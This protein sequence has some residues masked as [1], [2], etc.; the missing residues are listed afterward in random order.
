MSTQNL[1]PVLVAF[2]IS[3]NT[4][5]TRSYKEAASQTFKKGEAVYI[6]GS[7]YV[8]EYTASIDDGT[9]RMIGFAAEDAHNGTAGQYECLVNLACDDTVFSGNIY[10]GT[11]GSAVTAQ[12]DLTTLL[13]LKELP[14]QGTGMVAI[15]KEN[16]SGQL[17][18]ARILDFDK[19]HAIG[20]T[21][22][23]VLFVIE[24]AG[25]QIFQ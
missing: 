2:T 18:M 15:D 3:G 10:H 11:V 14:S 25:R 21:Y 16:T 24:A 19:N 9:Q 22:G 6:D 8:A 17:D 13:P 1:T 4:P 23:R 20:D 12:T 5:L 7:G